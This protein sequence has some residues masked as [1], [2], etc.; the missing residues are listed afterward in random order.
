MGDVIKLSDLS[1][2]QVPEKLKPV[3]YFDFEA[4]RFAH[5]SLVT[6]AKSVIEVLGRIAGYAKSWLTEKIDQN[7]RT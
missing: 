2:D 5:A 6:E 7:L 1:P 3:Y 4:H